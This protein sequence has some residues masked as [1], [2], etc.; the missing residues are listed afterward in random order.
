MLDL[1][2]RPEISLG[3]W[4]LEIGGLVENPQTF[5]WAQFNALPQFEDVSDFHCVT[6]WSKF[7]CRWQ[8]RS[9][10]HP[11]RSRSAESGSATCSFYQLRRLFN[12]RPPLRLS[13][14]RCP[15]R[16]SV[17]RQTD[18]ARARR[19]GPRHHSQAL[20][21]EGRQI[22]Q[23]NQ[24]LLPKTSLASGRSAVIATLR[25]PGRKTAFRERAD[26]G[27][28]QAYPHRRFRRASISFGVRPISESALRSN[29]FHRSS[30]RA[31]GFFSLA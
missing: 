10:L 25:T 1:G 24:S 9:L 23:D 28:A 5:T 16:D 14:R 3:E 31:S 19:A 2:I 20:C 15:D 17:R 4:R 6:T 30:W 11:R 21:L 13:R 26:A 18:H 29:R 8:G 22:R 7:D 27:A 12:K